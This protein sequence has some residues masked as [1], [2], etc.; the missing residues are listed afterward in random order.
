MNSRIIFACAENLATVALGGVV[1]ASSEVV[2]S[3]GNGA[4]DNLQ[5]IRMSR[6]WRSANAGE[7]YIDWHLADESAAGIRYV[8][9]EGINTA[10]AGGQE[11]RITLSHDP[12]HRSVIRD[13]GYSDLAYPPGSYGF[14]EMAWGTFPL[15]PQLGSARPC[16]R[17]Q[18]PILK[19]MPDGS[20][21]LETVAARY[22]RIWLRGDQ[23][24]GYWEARHLLVGM[25]FQPPVQ[26]QWG[27]QLGHEDL[28][29]TED[30]PWG[31]RFG[32]DRG[33]QTVQAVD[34]DHL[35]PASAYADLFRLSETVGTNRPFVVIPEV[36]V[37][38]FYG[39]AESG[40]FRLDSPIKMRE[41]QAN[42]WAVPV[43]LKEWK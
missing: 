13:S 12:K 17:I 29:E 18:Y 33:R 38:A 21:E 7:A 1:T 19:L 36:D 20:R 32:Q 42:R 10:S 4:A 2:A 8:G 31:Q 25:A 3:P 37:G 35:T 14:G 16:R 41:G 30:G 22:V 9:L 23:P 34:V 28:S 40:L 43:E 11:W 26:F 24:A 27:R 5:S 15:F 6:R 39:R